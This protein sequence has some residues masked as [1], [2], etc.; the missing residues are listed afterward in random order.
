MAFKMQL[1]INAVELALTNEQYKTTFQNVDNVNVSEAGTNLRAVTRTGIRK[2]HVE[3]K[4]TAAEEA[5]LEGY[6]QLTS[7]TAKYYDEVEEKLEEWPCWMSDFTSSL[8]VEDNATRFYK[9]S[10]NL[11]DL[12]SE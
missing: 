11:N 6:S 8:E 4:C 2:M 10:F 12:E 9:V 7:L 3:Y 1:F 5:K